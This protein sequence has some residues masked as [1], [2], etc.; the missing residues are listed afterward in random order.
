MVFGVHFCVQ[1]GCLVVKAR[2]GILVVR[3]VVGLVVGLV[4]AR[5]V[6]RVV[7]GLATCPE[8]DRSSFHGVLVLA[9]PQNALHCFGR[10]LQDRYLTCLPLE[11]AFHSFH[12]PQPAGI[13]NPQGYH[14]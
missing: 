9:S 13:L 4:V 5:V 10:P 7:G 8:Q 1:L 11:Q 14:R 2:I 6:G 12:N 3:R